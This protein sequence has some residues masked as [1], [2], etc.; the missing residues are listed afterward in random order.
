MTDRISIQVSASLTC[1][2]GSVVTINDKMVPE[3]QKIHRSG[4]GTVQL[5]YK[6]EHTTTSPKGTIDLKSGMRRCMTREDDRNWL[7]WLAVEY[8]GHVAIFTDIITAR[9]LNEDLESLA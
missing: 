9:W 8:P 1:S 4:D 3:F 2:N 6:D 5:V 7:A